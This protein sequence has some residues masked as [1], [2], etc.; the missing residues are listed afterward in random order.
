M[1][2]AASWLNKHGYFSGFKSGG[3]EWK[4][5]MGEVKSSIGL[6]VATGNQDSESNYVEFNYTITKHY[7]SEQIKKNY[8]VYLTTTP[9]NYGGVRYWFVCP[10]MVNS[11]PC[12]RRIGKLY[13]APA[14]EY[15][16]C[17]H[18]YDLTYQCQKKHDSRVDKLLRNPELL[19]SMLTNPNP[20]DSLLAAK[21]CMKVYG[22]F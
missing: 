20:R 2:I 19:E 22:S 12:K 14:G 18:C 10:L 9:C 11:R 17:R 16:G 5:S 6:L 3:I 13:M 21:A 4:N 8:K 1:S 7:S 15:F